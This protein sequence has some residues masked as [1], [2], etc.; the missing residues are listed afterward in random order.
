VVVDLAA[1]RPDGAVS[2]GAEKTETE[3]ESHMTDQELQKK[4][5]IAA[6]IDIAIAIAIGLAF[7][8]LGAVV[9]F[10]GARSE[11]ST[12]MMYVA[13]VLSFLGALVSVGYMLG[14]DVLGGGRSIGKKVQNINVVT[15][16]GQPIGFMDSAKRNVIFAIGSLF[17]LLSSTLQLVPCLGDVVA[18]LLTPLAVLGGLA[19][20][21]AV[22]IELVKISQDPNGVRLGDQWAGTRV[23]Y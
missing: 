18:C 1:S 22:I 8:I 19:S 2:V 10:A 5:Y 3:G 13:R 12:A 4:R 7:G 6:A 11:S 21:V 15:A 9:G 14:R 17:G 20:L 23:T 16:A